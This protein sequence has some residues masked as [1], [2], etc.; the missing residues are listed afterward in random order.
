VQ[1]ALFFPVFDS[2][3]KGRVE[4]G[5][6]GWLTGIVRGLPGDDLWNATL[7]V[8]LATF[9]KFSVTLSRDWRLA[10]VT[11]LSPSP[12]EPSVWIP[13][14]DRADLL[15]EV[16][17]LGIDRSIVD[18]ADTYELADSELPLMV[19]GPLSLLRAGT[20]VEIDGLRIPTPRPAGLVLEKLL[21]DRSGEKGD[22]DLLVV[23]GLL[24]AMHPPDLDELAAEAHG[25]S[26]EL[27]HLVRSNLALLLL[28]PGRIGMPD[29]A[30]RREQ[31]AQLA[32]R[33]D[34]V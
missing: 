24:A 9:L 4:Q 23:V 10:S 1:I 2:L 13:R 31:I 29:P 16:N 15:I 18:P 22:R 8:L 11:E 28:L 14:P 20:A 30:P 17:F 34:K 6:L 5:P 33:L 32:A 7:L 21:T 3:L 12:D 26:P 19:F 27:R 25:L